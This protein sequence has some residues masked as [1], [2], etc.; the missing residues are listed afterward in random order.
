MK[1]LTLLLLFLCFLSACNKEEDDDN[2]DI[3]EFPQKWELV[4]MTGQIPNSETT[5]DKMEWQEYYRLNLDS[6]FTKLRERNGEVVE[7]SGNFVFEE[8]SDGEYLVL[9]YKTDNILIGS[10]SNNLEEVLWLKSETK[11][12]STWL[13]CDG[14][15]LEYKRTE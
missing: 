15:G 9:S 4:K 10:C 7:A 12:T 14:P 8:L 3:D 2:F 11:M 5:G 1:Y 13:A 6:T